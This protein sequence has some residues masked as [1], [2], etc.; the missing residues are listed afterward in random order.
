[1]EKPGLLCIVKTNRPIAQH[2]LVKCWAPA[3]LRLLTRNSCCP[4]C[5]LSRWPQMSGY[6]CSVFI[7]VPIYS[8]IRGHSELWHRGKPNRLTEQDYRMKT[9]LAWITQHLTN[10]TRSH[11]WVERERRWLC[12]TS[13]MLLKQL[14]ALIYYSTF[15]KSRIMSHPNELR[16]ETS[17]VNKCHWSLMEDLSYPSSPAVALDPFHVNGDDLKYCYMFC[18]F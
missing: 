8:L 4:D 15:G 11:K 5:R 12:E 3:P 13:L 16:R 10:I 2:G 6:V 9:T 14:Y 18:S 7:N 17:R 1:M